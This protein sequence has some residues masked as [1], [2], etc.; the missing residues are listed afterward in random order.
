MEGC[1]LVMKEDITQRLI[2]RRHPWRRCGLVMKEDI[3]QPNLQREH[4]RKVV[5]W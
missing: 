1:G 5:V 3:T 2:R 4:E